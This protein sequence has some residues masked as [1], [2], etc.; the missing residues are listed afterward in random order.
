M[1]QNDPGNYGGI[2]FDKRIGLDTLIAFATLFVIVL[3][4]AI[5]QDRRVTIT[6]TQVK[7]LEATDVR[8]ETQQKSMQNDITKR[9]DRM[10][11]KLDRLVGRR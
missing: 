8:I 10:E 2:T 9:L 7:S 6:E 3:G 4:V 5:A 1:I 11:E